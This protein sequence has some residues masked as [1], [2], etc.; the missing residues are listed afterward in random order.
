MY[1]TDW[2]SLGNYKLQLYDPRTGG[3]MPSSPGLAMHVDVRDPDDK[4]II[5][6]VRYNIKYQDSWNILKIYKFRLTVVKDAS[7]L[8]LMILASMSFVY[9]PIQPN[10]FLGHNW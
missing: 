7:H 2:I 6:R 3:Y 8:L 1:K 9:I 5:S 4:N 10:G